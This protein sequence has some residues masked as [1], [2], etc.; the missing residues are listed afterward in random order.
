MSSHK[1]YVKGYKYSPGRGQQ[2]VGFGGDEISLNVNV[3]SSASNSHELGHIEIVW[4]DRGNGAGYFELRIS[5]DGSRVFGTRKN[6]K[7]NKKGVPSEPINL[8]EVP[9]AIEG[10]V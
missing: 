1:I 7:V 10:D 5:K 4:V 9:G 8:D 2:S 6:F 3:G